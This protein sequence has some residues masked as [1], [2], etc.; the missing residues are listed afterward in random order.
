[1]QFSEQHP[2]RD[3]DSLHRRSNVTVHERLF[4]V[5][6]LLLDLLLALMRS[7]TIGMAFRI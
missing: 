6:G 1:M 2:R 4:L 7:S 3:C 5:A